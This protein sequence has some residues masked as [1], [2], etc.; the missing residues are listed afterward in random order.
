MLYLHDLRAKLQDRKNRLYKVDA[1]QY[2]T[3]LRFFLQF[4]DSNPYLKALLRTLESDTTLDFSAW[5][6][7]HANRHQVKFPDSEAHR[8]TICYEILKLCAN[9]P[10]EREAYTWGMLF[11]FESN[12]GRILNDLTDAVAS[13]LVNFLHDR[14]EDVSSVLYLIERFKV[15]AEWFRRN[16][17]F[18]LYQEDTSVGEAALDQKLR[19]AL[20]EGGIDYPFSQPL[21]PSGEADVV[22]LIGS[23]DPLVLEVKVFDPERGKGKSNIRQGLHQAIRYADD[24]N[25][26]VGYVVV[27]N[28]SDGQL[29]FQGGP[30]EDSAV[31]ARVSQAGKTFFV[32]SV[33]IRPD[34]PSASKDRPATR[35]EIRYAEL[36]GA[37][38]S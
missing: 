16:E 18:Q 7:T 27:F 1:S 25:Q 14:I 33:D 20:F 23:G 11:S 15:R 21:S 22:A 8:A 6:E 29:A 32:I 28:C 26:P 10:G 36:V 2:G 30:D 12:I 24:Y 4:L 37:G 19:E 13:P 34:R 17:L 3:E 35:T 38:S 5:S 9:D 31:P